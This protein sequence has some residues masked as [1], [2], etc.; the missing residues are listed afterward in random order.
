MRK[1]PKAGA[2]CFEPVPC[3]PGGEDFAGGAILFIFALQLILGD[4]KE[5]TSDDPPPAPSI[6]IASF[7]L[8]VPLMASPQG[9]VAIV[10]IQATLR[11]VTQAVIFVALILCVMIINLGFLLAADR[12]LRQKFRPQFSR[13]Y[14]ASLD[15]CSARWLCS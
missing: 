12:N 2:S 13:S 6:E 10:A 9:L 4:D 5:A 7:P 3:W 8:A 11:G 14:C 1:R 15:C